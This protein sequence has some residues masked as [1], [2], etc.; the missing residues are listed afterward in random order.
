MVYY[1]A[2]V[3]DLWHM[4]HSGL[5]VVTES[6]KRFTITVIQHVMLCSKWLLTIPVSYISQPFFPFTNK[7]KG[8]RKP[9]QGHITKQ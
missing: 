8:F 7:N 6:F 9:V 1:I 3:A 4:C 2:V 5:Y